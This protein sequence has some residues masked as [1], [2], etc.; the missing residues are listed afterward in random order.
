MTQFT[1]AR[2][3]LGFALLALAA[4]GG[5]R[6]PEKTVGAEWR[7]RADGAREIP[8]DL[9]GSLQ[10]PCFSPDGA[11]LVITQWLDGYNEGKAA[12]HLVDLATGATRP[13]TDGSAVDVNMPGACWSADQNRITFASDAPGREE[14]FTIA[15]DGADLR[16]VTDAEGFVSFEPVFSPDGDRIA[17]ERHDDGPEAADAPGHIFV[18]PTEG[19][20]AVDLSSGASDDRQPNWA[21]TGVLY[22]TGDGA[23]DLV[24]LDPDQPMAP[25]PLTS[26][27]SDDTDASFS[28]DGERIVYSSDHGGLDHAS[29]F[30]TSLDGDEP[31]R[32]TQADGYDGAPS[33]SPDGAWLAF[34]A[35]PGEPDGDAT[36]VWIIAAP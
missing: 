24:L 11:E 30:V 35:S 9:A 16:Q 33:W 20:E 17:F 13:L 21:A 1:F 12:L 3:A 28:P 18:V 10:N 34:E 6:D 14:I 25:V 22:Q 19:G 27:P 26:G 8:I 15:P 29:L 7:T 32:A 4:C 36:T 23:H 5:S 31:V 2:R